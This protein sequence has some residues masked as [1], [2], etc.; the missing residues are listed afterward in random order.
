MSRLHTSFILGYHGCEESFGK[1]AINGKM[2]FRPSSKDYD[3]LGNGIYF[4]EGDP[5]RA[6]EWARE[7]MKRG[8]IRK[9]YVVGAIIDLGNCL[10]L[11]LRENAELARY[12]YDDL[13]IA[14]ERAGLSMPS[15][16]PPP[17]N[18]DDNDLVLRR[19]DCAVIERLY[20]IADQDNSLPKY[21]TA[22]A[23]FTEGKP[24]Y[25]SSGFREKTHIQIA[26]RNPDCIKGVFLPR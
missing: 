1:N 3:W 18:P 19:L 13:K 24:L 17:G 12:A 22:R 4:W 10:D 16:H 9:P 5:Q 6:L 2:K 25:E 11:T 20:S 8:G 23:L 15:N 21:D 14:Q 26:V 7:R